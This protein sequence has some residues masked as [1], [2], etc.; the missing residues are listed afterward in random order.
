LQRKEKIIA[1][2]ELLPKRNGGIIGINDEGFLRQFLA[3]AFFRFRFATDRAQA[4]L[5]ANTP[6]YIAVFCTFRLK[7]I[8]LPNTQKNPLLLKAGDFLLFH[9]GK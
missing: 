1:C 9:H 7:L 5:L 3:T 2:N 8:L 6:C 4:G